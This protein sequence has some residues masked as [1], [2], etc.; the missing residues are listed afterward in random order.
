MNLRLL[1]F[2]SEKATAAVP[3]EKQGSPEKMASATR[4]RTIDTRDDAAR[5]DPEE[6]HRT[7]LML[8]KTGNGKSTLANVIAGTHKEEPYTEVFE[9][10]QLQVS[11]TD[12]AQE[13][14]VEVEDG[15]KYRVVDTIGLCDTKRSDEEVMLKLARTC[16]YLRGGLSQILF[17]TSGRMTKEE[18]YAFR[19]IQ[20][21]LFNEDVCKFVTIV[22]TKT[23]FFQ[24]DAKCKRDIELAMA[25]SD[26]IRAMYEKV[27]KVIHVNNPGPDDRPDWP[28]IRDKTRLLILARLAR[29][30]RLYNPDSLQ[31]IQERVK[32]HVEKEKKLEQQLAELNAKMKEQQKEYEE[33]QAGLQKELR[34]IKDVHGKKVEAVR[35]DLQ[36]K[37]DKNEEVQR[38]QQKKWEEKEQTLMKEKD[39]A[40]KKAQESAKNAVQENCQRQIDNMLRQMGEMANRVTQLAVAQQKTEEEKR[41]LEGTLDKT[42]KEKKKLEGTLDTTLTTLGDEKSRANKAEKELQAQQYEALTTEIGKLKSKVKKQ[43]SDRET[44]DRKIQQL[45]GQV[46]ELQDRKC[47]IV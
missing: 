25:E 30:T 45:R 35:A 8:G 39:E 27:D 20:Q 40:Q 23:S 21:V 7:I 31:H 16:N 26:E 36:A 18:L 43:K 28:D 37:I 17:A 38:E 6:V 46:K 12:N 1:L 9:E 14:I 2:L 22:R 3:W 15:T 47:C 24:N 32:D 29:C 19:V 4:A 44:S 10:G 5:A 11:Q 41:K 13:Y 34:D 33:T 42:E